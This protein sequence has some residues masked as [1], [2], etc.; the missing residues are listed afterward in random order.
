[1]GELEHNS[2]L[3]NTARGGIVNEEAVAEGLSTGK[4]LGFS[5]DVYQTEPPEIKE[6][7]KADNVF[8]TPH[9][10]AYTQKAKIRLVEETI[11]V[12]AK[13]VYEIKIFNEIDQRFI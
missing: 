3:V 7:Y 2:W 1:L 13:F 10:G 9:M 11:K 5:T 6:F 12:W 4:I 8:L